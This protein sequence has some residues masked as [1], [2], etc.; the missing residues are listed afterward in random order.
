MY[1]K[2]VRRFLISFFF[3]LLFLSIANLKLAY[4]DSP[5][6][7]AT[8]ATLPPCQTFNDKGLCVEFNTAIGTINTTPSGFIQKVFGVILSFSG[9]IALL[10]IIFS[11]YRLMTSQGNPE[12]LQGARET[13]TAAIIGLLFIIFS[14]VILQLIGVDI[15]HIPGLVEK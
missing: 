13:L 3:L 2:I 1:D 14:L 12:K 9:G 15:L 11:G 4:S 8:P 6:P 10:L 5:I 7:S